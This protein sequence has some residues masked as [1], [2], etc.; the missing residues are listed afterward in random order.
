M[1]LGGQGIDHLDGVGLHPFDRTAAAL[2]ADM[3]LVLI[4]DARHDS[5]GRLQHVLQVG[6]AAVDELLRQGVG[7]EENLHVMAHQLVVVVEPLAH[8][9]GQGVE[10]AGPVVP[11]LDDPVAQVGMNP[12]GGAA[13]ILDAAAGGGAGVMRVHRHDDRLLD[14]FGGQL[15]QHLLG[16]RLPVAH[17]HVRPPLFSEALGDSRGL[18]LRPFEQGR[19]AADLLV[20]AAHLPRAEKSDH[21]RERLLQQTAE[22]QLDQVAIGEEV[23]EKGPD[24][25]ERVGTAHV[26]QDES[27]GFAVSSHLSSL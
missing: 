12:L 9:V 15:A 17:H 13:E 21:T 16:P 4:A 25:L 14:P 19:L 2:E 6:I 7:A 18:A 22:R 3:P 24:G 5:L 1:P 10:V 23:V 20:V 27:F 11:L 8:P 26:E